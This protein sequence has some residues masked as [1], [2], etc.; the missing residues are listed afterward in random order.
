M[1]KR[2]QLGKRIVSLTLATVLLLFTVVPANAAT[3][4]AL[5]SDAA[6]INSDGNI[7]SD[8][9]INSD[10][11]ARMRT[12]SVR[13]R[14][15]IASSKAKNMSKGWHSIGG[16]RYYF[17]KTGKY[18]KDEI[19]SISGKKYCFDKSG[20]LLYG[21][22]KYDGSHYYSD[23]KGVIRESAGFVTSDGYR[24]Y[25]TKGG[26]I[27]TG[28][29]FKV[30]GKTYKA[31]G[32]GKLG[33]GVFKYGTV[34]H[35]YADK[36][37]VVR[38]KAGFISWNGYRYYIT[39]N[40]GRLECGRTFKVKGKTYKAYS[41]GKLGTGVF[42]YGTT[43]R[44]YAD[45]YGVVKTTAGFVECLGNRYYV[46][47]GG[48]IELGHTFTVKGRKYKAFADGRLGTGIFKYGSKYYY[49]DSDGAIASKAGV[50]SFKKKYYYVNKNGSVAMNGLITAGSKKYMAN[51]DGTLKTGFFEDSGTKYYAGKKG[52]IVT[53]EGFLVVDGGTYYIQKG[54]A[55]FWG[56]TFTKN[57]KTYKAYASG[58]LGTGL[59]KY[60]SS[61]YYADGT[62]AVKTTEGL[63]T[64]SGKK[65]YVKKGGKIA[66]ST[67]ITTGGTTYKADSKG[68]LTAQKS[69][70]GTE[71]MKI[72]Q[73]EVGTKTG[74]KYWE[75]YFGTKFRNGDSTPW[76]GTFVTWCFKKAG[77]YSLIKDIED[78][79]NLGY[80]P[81]YSAY[82]NKKK[83]WVSA[84]KAKAGDIIIFG[85]SS[86]VGLVKSVSGNVITTIEGNTGSTRNGEVKQKTYSLTNSWIKGVMRVIR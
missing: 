86:H 72:A 83:I 73:K 40:A 61:Y 27:M 33:T 42:K 7:N 3:T 43:A 67:T 6:A 69:T 26:K 29:T 44:F 50:V 2:R 57:G 65:Y 59:F 66:V 10:G 4:G 52:E 70:T 60:G 5:N 17:Y 48:K 82:A 45:K 14:S 74:K 20:H 51:A 62:G 32:N 41:T 24:Y 54:G 76:C 75:A 39:K 37:G 55:I 30:S 1:N 13:G 12:F 64:V 11:N 16:Y 36:N 56:H 68:V 81:S 47:K 80:V 25:V 78:Y 8:G 23:S 71:L 77:L 19:K 35:F 31:Y 63:I 15:M 58:K 46:Q 21:V 79:G 34:A 85:S 53:K 38:T 9:A 18:Y 49:A 22:N 84:N 28:R